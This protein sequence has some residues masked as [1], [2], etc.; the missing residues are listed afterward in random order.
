MTKR[1][2]HTIPAAVPVPP[3][4]DESTVPSST[5]QGASAEPASVTPIDGLRRMFVRLSAADA[6]TLSASPNGVMLR[7][8]PS[9]SGQTD[10]QRAYRAAYAKRPDVRAKRTAYL[11][12]RRAAKRLAKAADATPS[13]NEHADERTASTSETSE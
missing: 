13:P 9:T 11:Q 6:D 2:K 3:V 8:F 7:V 12:S 4:V 1:K 10:K 5:E